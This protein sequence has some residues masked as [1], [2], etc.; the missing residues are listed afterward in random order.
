MQVFLKYFFVWMFLGKERWITVVLKLWFFSPLVFF[1][2]VVIL[3]DLKNSDGNFSEKQKIELNKVT[4]VH[5]NWTQ[6]GGMESMREVIAFHCQLQ[7]PYTCARLWGGQAMSS[8]KD[9]AWWTL[10]LLCDLITTLESEL[11]QAQPV[12][13]RMNE[14]IHVLSYGLT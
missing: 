13:L 6:Q 7:Q 4:V 12:K 11:C 10:F 2:Q 3:K 5:R 9:I 8:S 1:L 14:V